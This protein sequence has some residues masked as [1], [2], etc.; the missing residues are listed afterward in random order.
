MMVER[1]RASAV[2]RC[3]AIFRMV[4]V[5]KQDSTISSVTFEYEHFGALLVHTMNP[6]Q[7]AQFDVDF[8]KLYK[9][10][11]WPYDEATSV[12]VGTLVEQGE[13]SPKKKE[14]G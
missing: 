5:A 14:H 13:I 9:R 10:Y 8:I 7:R 2:V 4:N 11:A 6:C 12:R 1:L 3:V